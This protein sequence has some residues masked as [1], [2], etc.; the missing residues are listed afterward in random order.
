M[1]PLQNFQL[2]RYRV[3]LTARSTIVMPPYA[4]S[5]LRGRIRTRL[6]KDGL[7]PRTN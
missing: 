4:G 1:N 7:H 3:I 2:A 6:P 5:T